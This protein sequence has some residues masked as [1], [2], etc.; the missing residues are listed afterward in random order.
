M[1]YS[2]S[3]SQ[4]N[5]RRAVCVSPPLQNTVSCKPVRLLHTHRI[6]DVQR[7]LQ[8]VVIKQAIYSVQF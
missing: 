6:R 8:S 7:D 4:R 3:E 1:C 2:V 5:L